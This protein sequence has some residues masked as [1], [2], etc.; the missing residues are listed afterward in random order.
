VSRPELLG[1][2]VA[3]C[4][5]FDSEHPAG[6][7]GIDN[8]TFNVKV[9]SSILWLDVNVSHN[10]GSYM[11]SDGTL[12]PNDGTDDWKDATWQPTM[13]FGYRLRKVPDPGIG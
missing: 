10:A 12:I 8:E 4:L 11:A 3:G 13:R 6:S 1:H 7:I 9:L 5:S 2:R